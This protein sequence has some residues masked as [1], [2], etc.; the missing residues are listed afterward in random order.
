MGLFTEPVNQTHQILHTYRNSDGYGGSFY[1]NTPKTTY[2]YVAGY[3]F[4]IPN[5]DNSSFYGVCVTADGN[6]V[7]LQ[8]VD[9]SCSDD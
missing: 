2:G 7:A 1:S 5:T 6:L 9:A 4:D 3:T 8:Y